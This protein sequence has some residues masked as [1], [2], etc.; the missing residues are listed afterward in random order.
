[1]FK[2]D[3]EVDLDNNFV[4]KVPWMDPKM[5]LGDNLVEDLNIACEEL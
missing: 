1:M 4:E 5:V 3:E 2:M